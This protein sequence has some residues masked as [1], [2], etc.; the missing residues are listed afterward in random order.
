M[1]LETGT[2]TN[3]SNAVASSDFRIVKVQLSCAVSSH[4]LELEDYLIENM[5]MTWSK[6]ENDPTI[7]S[8]TPIYDHLRLLTCTFVDLLQ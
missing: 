6:N 7:K 4:L 8:T 1:I 2:I 5:K 3:S